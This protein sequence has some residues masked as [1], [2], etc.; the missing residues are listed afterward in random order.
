MKFGNMDVIETSLKDCYELVPKRFGD[1]RGY[2]SSVTD[3][4]L[5]MAGFDK[6]KQI[7]NSFSSKG[8]LRG[9][10]YQLNP[11]CQAKMVRCH[12]GAVL[13]VVVDVRKDSPTYGKYIAVELTPEKGNMLYVPRGFAHGFMALKDDS[14]FEYYVD[15]KY[16]PRLEDGIAYND[17]T[18]NIDWEA[19]KKQYDINE[20]ILSDKDSNRHGLDGML[21]EFTRKPK[22]FLITGY[23]GQLGYDLVRELNARGEYDILAL[24]KDDMDITNRDRVF[25]I[26][27]S[28]KPDVIFHCAAWTAVDKAEDMED[29]VRSIN[30]TGT[31]NLVDASIEVGAKMVYMSTD[32]V[33]DGKKEGLYTEEDK[34]NPQSVYG[35]TK[36]EGEEEVRRNPNHF[37]TRISWVFGINGNNFINTMLKLSNTHKELT[38]VDD[39]IGSP[40]YTVD[41]AKLLVE[42]SYTQ[43]Y[44][45]YNVNNEGYC[46]WA[47]F[48]KYI[49]ESNNKATKIIPVSTEEYLKITSA[50]QAYRPRNSKLD[51][52][53]LEENGFARLPSWQDATDRY[54]KELVRTN[55]MFLFE[56]PNK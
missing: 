52:S 44:G 56:H 13:D 40:T 50:K 1:N 18:I 49:M 42:M 22:K 26:V 25:E 24:D 55:K 31:K 37:I 7:S 19:I 10:H 35:L 21:G 38:V 2:F 32:Y 47:E 48:A 4:E 9:L 3:E 28:Y 12:Q 23:K 39:Q 45:T 20:L 15:N 34:V 8:V 36:Y 30:V 5:E 53:K 29:M 27:S 17:P 16:M 54:C 43:K 51:K 6:V 33:F 14:L 11:Y 41:L 46:S